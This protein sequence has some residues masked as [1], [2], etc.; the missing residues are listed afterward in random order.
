MACGQH[1]CALRTAVADDLVDALAVD[2]AD[3]IAAD[4]VVALAAELEAAL[5][6]AIV[7]A[8]AAAHGV[9]GDGGVVDV[10]VLRFRG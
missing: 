4:L 2:L 3:A 5:V 9:G 8:L 7:A 10:V 1:L 6:A